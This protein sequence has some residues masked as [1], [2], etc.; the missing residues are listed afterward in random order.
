MCFILFNRNLFER[1]RD[2]VPS[3]QSIRKCRSL[4]FKYCDV[5]F[6]ADVGVALLLPKMVSSNIRCGL[7]FS[8][9]YNSLGG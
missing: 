1:I 5:G 8:A 3:P 2:W 9:F 6:R 4:K 7:P